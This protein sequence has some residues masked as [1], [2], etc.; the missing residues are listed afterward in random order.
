MLTR[1]RKGTIAT[2][3]TIT[4]QGETVTFEVTYHNRRQSEVE[5]TLN[6]AL[7]QLENADDPGDG[8]PGVVLSMVESWD[9]EYPLTIEGI[10]EMED[11]RPG[12]LLGV[13]KGFHDARK[14]DKAKN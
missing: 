8:I 13:I 2:L 5:A 11:D 10:K 3:L 6:K 9:S 7:A 1:Q 12:I 14:V 4:G